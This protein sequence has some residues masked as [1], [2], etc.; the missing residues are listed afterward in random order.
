MTPSNQASLPAVPFKPGRIVTV[1]M[2]LIYI[3]IVGRTLAV[4]MARP[5][6][7]PGFAGCI[8][9]EAIFILLFTATIWRQGLP[10]LLFYAYFAV[11]SAILILVFIIEP[12]LDFI[13]VLFLLLCYQS[14]LNFTGWTCWAWIAL[15][16]VLTGGSLILD[17]GW[18]RGL[19]L[20]LMNIA[21]DIVIAAF[22]VT[23]REVQMAQARRQAMLLELQE[24]HEKLKLYSGQVEELA[25]IE[26]RNRLA[27]ELHDSVSQTM[28]SILLTTR[29]AQLLL[30]R[31]PAR[32]RAQLV[33]LQELVQ[34]AL[35]DMRSLITQLRVK[36]D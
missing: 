32:V 3:A 34:S 17:Q 18:L 2:Y 10:R 27:R 11:Q 30:E 33:Q 15:F 4:F 5:L 13:S 29:A 20:G 6:P 31:D 12:D 9:L 22:I 36:T 16:S 23:S 7:N 8:G 24:T 25:A 19:A 14:A 1:A 26:E 35:A 21:G 28:F